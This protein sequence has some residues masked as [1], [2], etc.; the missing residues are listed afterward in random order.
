[1]P[2]GQGHERYGQHARGQG[3]NPVKL[4]ARLE[5]AAGMEYLREGH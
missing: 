4:L 3:S 1:M 5:N 2:I